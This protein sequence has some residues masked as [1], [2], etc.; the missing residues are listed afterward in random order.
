MTLI[1]SVV[2]LVQH[3]V[4]DDV[5]LKFGVIPVGL[6]DTCVMVNRVDGQPANCGYRHACADGADRYVQ[7]SGNRWLF[8]GQGAK[9][10]S[11][12]RRKITRAPEGY[13]SRQQNCNQ[14]TEVRRRDLFHVATLAPIL[15]WRN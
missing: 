12:R 10:Q 2:E 15:L 4:G 7:E 11:H 8:R 14:Q 6:A 3:F 1:V 13:K 9:P 5:A